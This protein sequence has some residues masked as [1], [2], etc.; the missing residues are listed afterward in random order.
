MITYRRKFTTG[1]PVRCLLV[2]KKDC[3]GVAGNMNY[4]QIP[5]WNHC[6]RLVVESLGQIPKHASPF[7]MMQVNFSLTKENFTKALTVQKHTTVSK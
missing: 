7:I 2:S 5:G 3:I 6:L 1:N 4:D